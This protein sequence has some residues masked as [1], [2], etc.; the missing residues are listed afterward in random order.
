MSDVSALLV[1][2][3]FAGG[4]HTQARFALAE[5]F[6]RTEQPACVYL[7]GADFMAPGFRL[8]PRGSGGQPDRGPVMVVRD[9]AQTT[10]QSCLLLR[11]E[12]RRHFAPGTRVL[13][14]TSN[15]HAPRVSW[16]LRGMLGKAYPLS[17]V[18]SRDIAKGRISGNRRA[19]VLLVGEALSWLYCFP[20]GMVYRPL[21][22]ACTCAVA[23]LIA[24]GLARLRRRRKE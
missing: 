7:T 6:I 17:V 5:Q 24:V 9:E 16:L 12:V 15:Y 18:T 21:P 3:V 8:R 20:V 19:Q 14:V 4:P 1:M 11:R 10:L 13:V 2:V 23:A 22:L